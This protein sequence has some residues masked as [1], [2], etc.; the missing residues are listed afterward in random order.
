MALAIAW[1]PSSAR[2]P[3]LN[4][5]FPLLQKLALALLITKP[6]DYAV[7]EKCLR[8]MYVQLGTAGGAHQH[9]SPQAALHRL[10]IVRQISGRVNVQKRENASTPR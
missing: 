4:V 7:V 3:G 1:W 10:L 2:R 8:A 9:L 5:A 6:N